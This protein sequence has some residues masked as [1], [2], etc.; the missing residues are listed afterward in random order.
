MKRLRA[1]LHLALATFT[2]VVLGA[3]ALATSRALRWS[4]GSSPHRG[5]YLR[6][7]P[8]SAAAVLV[9]VMTVLSAGPV[10][11]AEPTFT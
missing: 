11:A 9:L 6:L 8:L 4:R 1:R 7:L 5:S 10:L 2:L 3:A